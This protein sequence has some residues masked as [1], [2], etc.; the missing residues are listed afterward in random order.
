M[1][2]TYKIGAFFYSVFETLNENSLDAEIINVLKKYY[3][4]ESINSLIYIDCQI[5]IILLIKYIYF[6]LL[7]K[8][9]AKNINPIFNFSLL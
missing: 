6:L 2:I 4:S 5:V 9:V 7:S 1:K 3:D 8:K